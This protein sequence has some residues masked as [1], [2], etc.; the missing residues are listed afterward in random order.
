MDRLRHA[1]LNVARD[2]IAG[3]IGDY[4]R[5]RGRDADGSRRT[6]FVAV[7]GPETAWHGAEARS[8]QNL[9]DGANRTILVVEMTETG[10]PWIAKLQLRALIFPDGILG[11]TE[12]GHDIQDFE[13]AV[14]LRLILCLIPQL[15]EGNLDLVASHT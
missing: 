8:Q 12:S 15:L 10:I 11:R 13:D 2:R 9:R 14:L 3:R 7:V 5:R 6:C 1:A 4:Y